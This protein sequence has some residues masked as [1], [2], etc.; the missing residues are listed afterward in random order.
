MA[1]STA[2]YPYLA[3][4]QT[5]A[6]NTASFIPLGLKTSKQLNFANEAT[7]MLQVAN[8]GP[9]VV[10]LYASDNFQQY[11]SG[12]FSDTTCFSGDCEQFNHS[13]VVVGYGTDLE[14]GPYWLCKNTW[15]RIKS[16]IFKLILKFLKF[17][18]I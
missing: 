15:V 9:Q 16:R 18:K 5:C 13:V 11:S 6:N 7:L 12:V 3:A 2:V 8:C 1:P 17:K 4:N 14:H 10:A